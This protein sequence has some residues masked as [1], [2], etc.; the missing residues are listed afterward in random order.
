MWPVRPTEATAVCRVRRGGFRRIELLVVIAII[1]ILFP[2][3]ART[4][5]ANC[6]SNLKQIGLAVQMY[7][8]NWDELVPPANQFPAESPPADGYHQA[9]PASRMFL[10]PTPRTSG[11]SAARAIGT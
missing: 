8:Q 3:F 2:V 11:S 10:S 1:A 9:R 6:T 4:R 7:A 5:E